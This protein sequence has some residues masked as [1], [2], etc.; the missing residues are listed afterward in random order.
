MATT[1]KKIIVIIGVVIALFCVEILREW[2]WYMYKLKTYQASYWKI[3]TDLNKKDVKAIIGEPDFIENTDAEYWHYNS[4]IYQGFLWRK[5]RL[6][7]AGEFYRL[8]VQF[9]KEGMVTDVFSF[10]Y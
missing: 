4:E 5:L 3:K 8:E 1:R 7:R 2:V 6:H 9:D 10:G